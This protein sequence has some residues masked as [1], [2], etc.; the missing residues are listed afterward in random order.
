MEKQHKV[1]YE[2]VCTVQVKMQNQLT[3][4]IIKAFE[5][6]DIEFGNELKE[7]IDESKSGQKD[8]TQ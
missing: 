7:M 3:E 6:P 8:G 4:D 2:D 1:S 5:T